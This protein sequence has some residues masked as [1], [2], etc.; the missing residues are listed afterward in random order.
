M[1]STTII[2]K[3]FNDLN[4]NHRR[5]VPHVLAVLICEDLFAVVMMVL[6]SSIALNNSVEGSELLMSIAKLVFFLV[7]WFTVGVSYS[8][9]LQKCASAYQRRDIACG[10][11]GHVFLYG[12]I[13]GVFGILDGTWSLC[14]GLDTCRDM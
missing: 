5:F 3:A 1:S 8:I 2:I 9:V 7:I 14:D 6:L 11:N 12:C 4:M 10:G 13:L